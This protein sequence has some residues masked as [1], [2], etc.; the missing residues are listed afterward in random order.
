MENNTP[1]TQNGKSKK[2]KNETPD[3]NS[4]RWFLVKATI[5]LMFFDLLVFVITRDATVLLENTLIGV[6]VTAIYLF[7][8]QKK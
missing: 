5:A 3:D 7:Y 1:L 8:F 4:I 6:A 2:D